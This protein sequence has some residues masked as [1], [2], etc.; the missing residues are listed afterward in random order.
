MALGP[1]ITDINSD[2]VAYSTK[3]RTQIEPQIFTAPLSCIK[4]D[5]ITDNLI[6]KCGI[7]AHERLRLTFLANGAQ[8]LIEEMA[9]RAPRG[10]SVILKKAKYGSPKGCSCLRFVNYWNKYR[11]CATDAENELTKIHFAGQEWL[12]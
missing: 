2:G 1:W 11:R 5:V 3:F 9:A 6:K 7:F 4:P 10:A 8:L 12:Q